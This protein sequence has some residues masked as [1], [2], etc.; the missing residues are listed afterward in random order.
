MAVGHKALPRRKMIVL[1]R[2]AEADI[3]CIAE[4]QGEVADLATLR[5]G[6]GGLRNV[7]GAGEDLEEV[8]DLRARTSTLTQLAA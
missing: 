5:G 1:H 2:L 7:G 4:V 3:T 6:L 8:V